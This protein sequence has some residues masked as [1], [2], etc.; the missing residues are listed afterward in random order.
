MCNHIRLLLAIAILFCCLSLME[1]FLR[2]GEVR[3][4]VGKD[5]CCPACGFPIP[6]RSIRCP[7]CE[8]RLIWRNDNA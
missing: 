7:Y 8:T 4:T 1:I 2:D 3:R 6:D 5:S